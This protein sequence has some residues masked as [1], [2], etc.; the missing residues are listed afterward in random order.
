MEYRRL[1]KAGI[2]V[3]E[4][5]FGSW[6]TFG[7][8]LD[9]QGA[10]KL[11]RHAYERG[12]NFFDN[13][14]AYGG[15]ASELIMGEALR[16]YKR[17]DVVISTKIFWG[18]SGPNDRGLSFKHL[19]EGTKRSLKRLKTDYVDL[20]F[21]H[22]PDP[23]TPI[24]ET[25]RAMDVLIRSGHCFYWGTSE[26]SRDQIEEAHAVAKAINATPPSMEQPQ[27]NMLHRDRMEREYLPL[28]TQYGMGATIWSPLSGGLLTG[29]Y[30]QGIPKG[31][32]FFF[33]PEFKRQLTERGEEVLLDLER[34]A[35]SLE[36]T[37]GQLAIA[38]CLKNRNVST[39][40]LGATSL[41]QLEENLRVQELKNRLTEDVKR[42]IEG[43]FEAGGVLAL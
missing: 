13:A 18:G 39:V 7:S 8:S 10:K 28:F 11:M 42:E 1:G 29:K 33:H 23:E 37:P 40:I 22:R 31:S 35:K 4:L 26:W 43:I 21:C 34:I 2:K 19:V 41:P 16:D 5:S 32:R 38:W 27:Y 30:K 12:V 15:G 25:V 36:M 24:E 3:S 14:E 6:I 9:L 17:E 20:L